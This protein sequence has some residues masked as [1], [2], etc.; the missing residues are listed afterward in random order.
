MW[1]LADYYLLSTSH[2]TVYPPQTNHQPKFSFYKTILT[3]KFLYLDLSMPFCKTVSSVHKVW[4]FWWEE[5]QG[6]QLTL[7]TKLW[8]H[9]T[10]LKTLFN[11]LLTT[12][13]TFDERN[14]EYDSCFLGCLVS[15][16]FVIVR[17]C[18][19]PTAQR[20]TTDIPQHFIQPVSQDPVKFV[21]QPSCESNELGNQPV[22]ITLW[23][24]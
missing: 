16:P 15:A 18:P 11:T 22:R 17:P 12:A 9:L 7:L 13:D 23:P 14:E 6:W 8:R 24:S 19:T 5:W 21:P 4:H 20:A 1:T 2:Q 3:R 10:L